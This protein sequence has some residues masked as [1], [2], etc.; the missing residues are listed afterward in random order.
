MLLAAAR[1][2]S[3]SRSFDGTVVLIFQ[4][5]E[6]GGAGADRMIREGLFD[7]FNCDAVFALHNWPGLAVG[8]FGVAPGPMLA[9]TNEFDIQVTGRGG[10]AAMPHWP[11]TRFW[12]PYRSCKG[13]RASSRAPGTRSTPPYCR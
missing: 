4:P 11:S 8:Q 6:E 3:S 10:H 12:S 7:R 1:H 9:S 2:L 13:F 5:A